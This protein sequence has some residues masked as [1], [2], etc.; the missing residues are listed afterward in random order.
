[1]SYIV[2]SFKL[3]RAFLIASVSIASFAAHAADGD[4]CCD[5]GTGD[6]GAHQHSYQGLKVALLFGVK[7]YSGKLTPLV[8]PVNDARDFAAILGD[9]GFSVRCVANPQRK[10]ALS[11]LKHLADY[12]FQKDVSNSLRKQDTRI[13][14]YFAGHGFQLDSADYFFFKTDSPLNSKADIQEAALSRREIFDELAGLEK[15]EP[16][17]IF[18]ACRV[19]FNFANDDRS[20]ATRSA[21]YPSKD[22]TNPNPRAAVSGYYVV[23]STTANGVAWNSS[24]VK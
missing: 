15:F 17:Y 9:N 6:C 2:R 5:A 8:N 18:D 16:H 12:L 24:A 11:E 21:D 14:V 20:A 22:I 3:L 10:E 19:L 7:D 23:H 13:F 1:M 4:T